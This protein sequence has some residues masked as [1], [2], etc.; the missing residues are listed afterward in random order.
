MKLMNRL[1]LRFLVWISL[2]ITFT[3]PLDLLAVQPSVNH[4]AVPNSLSQITVENF[5][6]LDVKSLRNTDGKKFGFGKRVAARM[7]Q[8]SLAQQVKKGK[9]DSSTSLQ[10]AMRGTGASKRGVPSVI[11]STLGIIFLFI[12]NFGIVGLGLSIAGFVLGIIG[13]NRDEDI[14][15]ALIGTILGAVVLAIYLIAIIFI[16]SFAF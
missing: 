7:I 15:L 8:K 3:I 13:L 4:Y 5:L 1:S 2:V 11:F 14:T 12:P 6:A 9:L 10:E 16:A